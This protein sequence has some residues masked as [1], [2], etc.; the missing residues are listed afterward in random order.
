MSKTLIERTTLS[1]LH[2][3]LVY[4]EAICTAP[5]DST[6]IVLGACFVDARR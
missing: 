2:F 3:G 5:P 1:N 4:K 6:K